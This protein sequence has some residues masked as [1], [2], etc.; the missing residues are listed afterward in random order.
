MT[1]STQD[2]WAIRWEV[3]DPKW[4]CSTA[5]PTNPHCTVT[6]W[7]IMYSGTS[8]LQC[9]SFHKVIQGVICLKTNTYPICA[10]FVTQKTHGWSY[11]YHEKGCPAK[12]LSFDNRNILSVNLILSW[13]SNWDYEGRSRSQ[14][15]L[16]M[17]AFFEVEATIPDLQILFLKPLEC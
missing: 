5:L 4:S 9:H 3:W 8:V 6:S 12:N 7:K 13:K 2:S 17:E 15:W 11:R 1:L 14:V 10:F 16:S